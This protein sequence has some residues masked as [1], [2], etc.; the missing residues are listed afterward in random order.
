MNR[1]ATVL[2]I[3]VVAAV[4]PAVAIADVMITGSFT[5]QTG[6]NNVAWYLQ[7]GSNYPEAYEMGAIEWTPSEGP[8]SMGVLDLQGSMIAD[9]YMLN[10]LDLHFGLSPQAS[11][12]TATFYLN[13]SGSTIPTGA[14]MAISVAPLNMDQITGLVVTTFS[15]GDPPVVL[16]ASSPSAV[17]LVYLSENP[18]VAISN[19]PDPY[20]PSE[21][22]YTLS[23]ALP[24]G[25][26]ADTVA[27]MT[28]QFVV[29]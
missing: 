17:V 8:S 12:G 18:H 21:H 15:A 24:A 1:K 3:A 13:V 23:F 9:T 29:T 6:S 26:Y 11:P 10:V 4:L 25:A 5:L 2:M 14:I 27:T 22:F 20:I 19:F 16:D 28:G 7:P